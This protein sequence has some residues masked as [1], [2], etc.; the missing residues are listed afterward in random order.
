MS[1]YQRQTYMQKRIKQELYENFSIYLPSQ[2]DH[3]VVEMN[4]MCVPAITTIRGFAH[5]YIFAKRYA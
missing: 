2:A 1:I 3:V 4:V 5:L